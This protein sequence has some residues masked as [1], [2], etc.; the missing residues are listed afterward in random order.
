MHTQP[1]PSAYEVCARLATAKAREPL[2]AAIPGHRLAL[3]PEAWM[4]HW[5]RPDQLPPDSNWRTWLLLGG[6]GSGKTRAAAEWVRERMESGTASRLALIGPTFA[7]VRDVMVQ[8]PSGLIAT[9]SDGH[10]PVYQSSLR[11]L[12]WPDGAHAL[13]FSAEDPDSLRG[14][15]F[16]LAWGDEI[17]AWARPDA[18][19]DVLRPAL[20]LGEDP[21]LV[22]S[23]TPRPIS[24][25]RRLLGDGTCAVSRARTRDNAANL[26]PG[27]VQD[28]EARYAGSIW[29]RQELD[30]ELIEDPAGALWTRTDLEAAR[31][32]FEDTLL[33]RIIVAVDP[34]ASDGPRADRCGIIVAGGC[35][36]GRTASATV[37]AD[38]SVQGLSPAGWAS[39]VAG[40]FEAY[41]ADC[42]IVEANQGGEMVRTVLHQRA[43][44]A[45]VRLVHARRAKRARA[46]PVTL[47]YAAGRVAHA[48]HFQE[49]EDEMCR[50][51]APGFSGSPD[52]MDAL[53][54]ALTDLLLTAPGEPRARTL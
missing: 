24:A 53:V 20:R 15:Q 38:C 50:F 8:G 51:G 54:W 5:A 27:T 9:A 25:V 13:L 22:L 33:D 42:I 2:L 19:L 16:D 37:L 3:L 28:L 31:A 32:R 35:G 49:L 45:P 17:A 36:S 41:E 29:A 47:L 44:D 34:P 12:A 26:A 48:G 39:A 18:V 21:R 52:R 43:P 1:A 6:R 14:P 40:A 23:T 46:E 4:Q 30:G 11:R 7:D 10:R